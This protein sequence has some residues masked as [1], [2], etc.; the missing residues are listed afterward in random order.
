MSDDDQ[1][2]DYA[3]FA[4]YF[5]VLE[6]AREDQPLR[7]TAYLYCPNCTWMRDFD[8]DATSDM[9]KCSRCGSLI[10]YH[11]SSR[12]GEFLDNPIADGL[13]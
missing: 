8:Y 9:Y 11:K 13:G 5:S 7:Q 4:G 3:A 10:K 12:R 2:T 6:A 1:W